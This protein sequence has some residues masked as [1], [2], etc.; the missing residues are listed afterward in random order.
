MSYAAAIESLFALAGELHSAPGQR[1]RKFDLEHMRVLAEALGHPERKFPS[2]LIAGTNGKGSTSATLAS[3]LQAAG[4]RTGLYTS[5]HLVRVNE[6][7]RIDGAEIS[8]DDFARLYFTV[9]DV[10]RRL[11]HEGRLPH[12]PS[13]F[14]T[15]TALAFSA[16]AQAKL[17]I[18]VLEVGMGGRLDATNIVDPLL[19]IITD[20]S[21]DHTEWLGPTISAIAREKAGI[22]RPG[23][24]MVTLPQHPEANQVLGEVATALKV[25]G[26]NAAEYLPPRSV[27]SGPYP[28]Q[29]L[30][31]QVE[32]ASPLA[33]QH[34]QRNL[35]LAIAAAVELSNHHGYI[36]T[37]AQMAEGIQNTR[38]PGRLESFRSISG[39]RIL[40][41]VGHN[42]AGAWALRA[43]LAQTS[44][45]PRVLIFGCLKDKPVFEM[46]QILFPLFD[47]VLL[48]VVDSP[49]AA[50]MAELE[51]AAQATGAAYEAMPDAGTALRYAQEMVPASGLIVGT[52]SVYLV[53]KL[54]AEL[55]Q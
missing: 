36:M 9:D 2:V 33:G 25:R 53:G 12:P 11:V 7:V 38:W 37:P 3:I 15:M 19:S 22:L 21:L 13:F 10:A 26:V 52:G 54:R 55:A 4:Y 16:F 44:E 43:A 51:A 5:P 27:A 17:D 20:I 29:L 47:R 49:R 40:L 18:A 14:E 23:G 42:P 35:A 31:E 46:A 30:G 50:D 8:D 6:R 45:Q 34:Q 1:R 48:S 28:L 41:D 39:A 32:I 24:V